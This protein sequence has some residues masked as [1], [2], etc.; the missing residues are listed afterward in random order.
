MGA[1]FFLIPY[2]NENASYLLIRVTSSNTN[3]IA[4][5]KN[6]YQK[7]SL[8]TDSFHLFKIHFYRDGHK[9]KAK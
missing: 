1:F 7:H 4:F 6:N 2:R 8:I 3:K 9:S 5:R